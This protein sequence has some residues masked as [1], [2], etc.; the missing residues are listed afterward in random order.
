MGPAGHPARP[1]RDLLHQGPVPAD[2]H[3]PD[4]YHQH[5]ADH[6]HGEVL[7]GAAR[8]VRHP[9]AGG[10]APE[11]RPVQEAAH[12]HRQGLPAVAAAKESS[13]NFKEVDFMHMWFCWG[14]GGGGGGG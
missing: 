1:A 10:G 2:V 8:G 4:G 13:Q 7:E 6:E 9:Q 3:F 11:E 12:L 5:A 14:G